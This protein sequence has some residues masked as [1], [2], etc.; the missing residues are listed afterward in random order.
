MNKQRTFFRDRDVRCYHLFTS[1]KVEGSSVE[2]ARHRGRDKS[3]KG[4]NLLSAKPRIGI[5]YRTS[6]WSALCVVYV[7][8]PPFLLSVFKFLFLFLCSCPDMTLIKLS[9]R[10]PSRLYPV[11]HRRCPPPTFSRRIDST[12]FL[13][14]FSSQGI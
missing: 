12:R 6:L 9:F 8:G 10:L 5:F 2:L 14:L 13:S 4:L 1:C 3:E 11:I 7:I